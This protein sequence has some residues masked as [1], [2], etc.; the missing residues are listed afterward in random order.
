[1]R[2]IVLMLLLLFAPVANAQFGA[3]FGFKVPLL[4]PQSAN[5]ERELQLPLSRPPLWPMNVVQIEANSKL[6][7]N[8]ICRSS[9]GRL[10]ICAAVRKMR[11]GALRGIR[12]SEEPWPT[13]LYK[14]NEGN[15]EIELIWQE[16]RI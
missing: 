11:D 16:E 9:S 6:I 15:E 7:E 2:K 12:F 3:Q 5:A 8:K 14:L 10:Y 1:M 4:P 13:R